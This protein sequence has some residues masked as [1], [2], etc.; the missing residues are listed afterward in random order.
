MAFKFKFTSLMKY[1]KR[2]ED[3]AQREYLQARRNLDDCL[4]LIQQYYESMEKARQ[5]I[6]IHQ[7][8]G[9]SGALSQILT[10]EHFIDGQKIRVTNER[11]R[12]RELMAK[13][14]EKQ[15]LLIE[16]TREHKKLEKLEERMRDVYRKD[17]K[18]R[19]AKQV[20]DLV[21]IRS[22]RRAIV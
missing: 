19:E 12:A 17:E 22:R 1:R 4:M 21:V 15:E 6:G 9:D 18:R 16:A 11:T 7:R 10:L 13:V 20:D 2:M 5:E 8:S 3:A 14:E